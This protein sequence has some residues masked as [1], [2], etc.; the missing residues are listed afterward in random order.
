[1]SQTPLRFLFVALLGS[2]F[3]LGSAQVKRTLKPED[4]G[5]WETLVA[6]LISN[7]G[8]WISYQLPR[9]DGDSRLVIRNSD[10]P[11]KADIPGGKSAQFSDDSKWFGYLIS[12]PKAIAEKLQEEKKPVETR[13]AL[14]NL[15]NGAEIMYEGIVPVPKREQECRSACLSRCGKGGG[16]Q[17]LCVDQPSNR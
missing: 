15:A 3:C 9:V 11:E 10:G 7:D 5:Q 12:P 4:Y 8:H 17:R 13:F 14:R 2:A 6:P 1:M 16:W